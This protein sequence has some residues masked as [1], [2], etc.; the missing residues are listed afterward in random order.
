MTIRDV[1]VHIDSSTASTPRLQL[2]LRMVRE[3]SAN[4]VGLYVI[5]TYEIPVYAEVSVGP[6]I[7]EQGTQ[8][9]REKADTVRSALDSMIDE[10]GVPMHWHVVE[11]DLVRALVRHARV[12]DLTIV[13]QGDV[14]DQ[15]D[16]STGLADR[17]V[18]EAG[19]PILVVPRKGWQGTLGKRVLIAW[20]GSRESARA[21]RDAVPLLKDAESVEVLSIWPKAEQPGESGA[22]DIV[23]HLVRHGIRAGTHSLVGKE[24][25]AGTVL[26]D[27]ARGTDRDLLVMGGYGHSRFRETIL[28]GA[29]RRVLRDAAIPVFM[30]H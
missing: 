9:L 13:G 28:G 24:K 19:A 12:V 20:N 23:A 27:R 22:E 16:V 26:L 15:E 17:V 5:P 29:T 25:D 14:E 10:S 7:L 30:S 1:V 11:D 18:L 3:H 4:L 6:E 2:A 21:V 8:A